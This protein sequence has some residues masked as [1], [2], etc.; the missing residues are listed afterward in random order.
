MT[1]WA[2]SIIA[3]LSISVVEYLNRTGGY[4]N[5]STAL[6]HTFPFIAA[7]QL[8]LFYCWRDAPSFMLAWCT[9]TVGNSLLRMVSA[10]FLVGEPLSWY[11]VAGVSTMFLG[12]YF[13]KVG[14]A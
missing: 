10:Q 3:N 8:G 14:A 2:A 12:T 9:F 4:E 13:I 5:F 1:W 11:T 6:L 7:A